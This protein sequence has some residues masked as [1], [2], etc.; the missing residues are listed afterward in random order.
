MIS[1]GAHFI[2]LAICAGWTVLGV[3]SASADPQ[4]NDWIQPAIDT[5]KSS[6]KGTQERIDAVALLTER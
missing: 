4:T 1:V 2:R 5:A 3:A 6:V